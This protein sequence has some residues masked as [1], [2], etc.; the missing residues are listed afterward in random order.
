MEF[1][2]TGSIY[3]EESDLAE[4]CLLCKEEGYTPLKAFNEVSKGWDDCDYYMADFIEDD[5]VKEIER[6]LKEN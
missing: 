1:E 3:V 2:F 5:V 6:R 4:M